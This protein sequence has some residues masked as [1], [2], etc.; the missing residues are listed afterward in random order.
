MCAEGDLPII[1]MKAD[2]TMI[3]PQRLELAGEETLMDIFQM[4]PDLMIAGYEDLI[5][6]YNL[7]IDNCPVNGDNRLIL[8]Q[9]KAKDIKRI[10]VCDNTGV[11][12][13][14]IG[15]G[16]V[17]DI[18][19]KMPEKVKG[20]VEGQ[21]DFGKDVQGIGSV[22]A[23][24]G[25]QHTDLYANASYRHNDGNEEHLTLHMT[26]RFDDRNRLLTYFT[27][28]F[29]DHPSGASRKL[30]GRARYFH[31]FNDIG[32]ELLLVGGYQYASDP[33]I[34]NKLPMCSVELNT[35]FLTK[36]LSMMLGYESDF[37][38]TRQEDTD[39]NWDVFNHDLY[40]QFTYALPQWRFT[41]GGRVMFYNYKMKD[42]GTTQKYNDTRTNAN[43]C[44]IYVPDNR[45]Q[46]QLG[47]YRKYSNPVYSI[48]FMDAETISEEEWTM[49][50]GQ[51]EEQT[52]NQ[53]KL[54]YAYSRQKLTVQTEA[55]YYV[56]EDGE[57]FTQLGASA[58]WKKDWLSISGGANLY[59]AE[60]RTYAAFWLAPHADLPHAWQIGL[61]L[62]YYTKES[63]R[64]ELTGEPV[65]GCLSV[66]KQFGKRWNLG[67]DWHDMFDAVC[68]DVA[69]NR[70]AAN[71]K[72][73]YR[74]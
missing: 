43:A 17:L 66:N 70:H 74:F 18:E 45:N 33:I 26:N 42:V 2:R 24:Y 9:M 58:Y 44:V 28:Q 48:L 37:L 20:F 22:N 47:Y 21:G 53:M 61:Q 60:S 32:T 1:E 7:R 65:Y 11:A 25:S 15:M 50:K 57:N 63:P 40:L 3:Y 73:Q 51:L 67:V 52:I 68:S 72:L 62:V 23:L 69:V 5:S 13:G 8:S 46:I 29:L 71:I 49:T 56:I 41:A 55:S 31:I 16:R 35:P 34:S 12:K 6:N 39:R 36:R 64:R 27:Q 54:A 10:Q 38:M 14:T 19:M 59:I 30:M 4:V